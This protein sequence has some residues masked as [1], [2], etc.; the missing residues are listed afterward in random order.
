MV[1]RVDRTVFSWET[2]G[3]NEN[4]ADIVSGFFAKTGIG[5]VTVS[6]ANKIKPAETLAA[7]VGLLDGKYAEG[8]GDLRTVSGG[9][10]EFFGEIHHR[11]F[12]GLE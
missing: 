4:S 1:E 7:F 2:T 6:Q 3:A 9:R 10:L 5:A 12:D 8:L 11:K